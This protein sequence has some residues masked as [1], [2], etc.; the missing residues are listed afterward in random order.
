MNDELKGF[1]PSI[2]IVDTFGNVNKKFIEKK[3]INNTAYSRE[4]GRLVAAGKKDVYYSLLIKRN[5]ILLLTL[6]KNEELTEKTYSLRPNIDDSYFPTSILVDESGSI[7]ILGNI[8]YKESLAY[9]VGFLLKLDQDGNQIYWKLYEKGND[10]VNLIGSFFNKIGNIVLY[11]NHIKN[12]FPKFDTKAIIFEIGPEDGSLIKSS[13]MDN[14]F[15]VGQLYGL[16]ENK[17]NTYSAVNLRLDYN[18]HNDYLPYLNILDSNFIT[19]KTLPFGTKETQLTPQWPSHSAQDSSENV[20]VATRGFVFKSFPQLDDSNAVEVMTLTKFSRE[21]DIIWET[22][23]TVDFRAMGSKY[24]RVS[25][26]TVITSVN[27]A[28]SGSVFVT[29]YYNDID[30]IFYVDTITKAYYWA[31]DSLSMQWYTA[32]KDTLGYDTS[33]R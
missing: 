33:R 8:Q 2:L 23:D 19:I 28:S 18:Y 3:L 11:G 31:Y 6:D 25:R 10:Q 9:T 26:Q 13:I 27:V 4:F 24:D 22:I 21:G 32:V 7:Y 14:K 5:E 29:G 17:N 12:N 1:F 20:L 16:F 30:D 15:I